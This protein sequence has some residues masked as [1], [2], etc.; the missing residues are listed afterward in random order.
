VTNQALLWEHKDFQDRTVWLWEQLAARYKDTA[1]IAGYNVLNEPC[2]AQ[3]ARLPVLYARLAA[4]IRAVDPRHILWLDG[5]TF[6]M[7][8]RAF[9]APLPNCVYSLHDYSSMG[10]PKGDHYIGSPDQKD[11]LERQFLRKARFMHER[12]L[13][14]WNG[15]FGPVYAD[16]QLDD[17][18]QATNEAR[19]ALLAEQLS[20]YD[21]FKIHWSIWL[22][23]DIG[24]QGMVYTGP[25]S[26]YIRTIA[27]LLAKKRELQVDAWGRRPAP[28]IEGIIA[29]LVEWIDKKAPAS[30]DMYPTPWAT[31]RQISRLV[32][33]LW[34]AGCLQDEFADLFKGMSM[35]DLDECAKSFA[36]GQCVQR[37]GLNKTL[38]DHARL[39]VEGEGDYNAPN[40]QQT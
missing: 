23:K 7:E 13:P 27:P 18:A 16:D 12:G 14:V 5:N 29:P 10:F 1:W 22:Y 26:R 21:K 33:Q 30:K 6:A 28:E 31:E 11:R 25:S 24:Y 17:D 32:L 37:E 38:E 3:H 2:D 20:I 40:Y 35:E 8:W 15:E 36:F 4:A 9:D 34:V 19:Y 39:R